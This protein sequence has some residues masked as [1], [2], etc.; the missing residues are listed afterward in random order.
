[1]LGVDNGGANNLQKFQNNHLVT[2]KGRALMILQSNG[3][4]RAD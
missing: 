4:K 2:S 1:M 3:A